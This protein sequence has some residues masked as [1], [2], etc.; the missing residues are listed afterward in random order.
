M[1]ARVSEVPDVNDLLAQTKGYPAARKLAC[2][3]VSS[4]NDIVWHALDFAMDDEL[5]RYDPGPEFLIGGLK[6]VICPLIRVGLFGSSPWPL[7]LSG[8]P[9]RT[10]LFTPRQQR[11]IMVAL[12]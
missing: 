2:D 12:P 10:C 9:C 8:R 4:A 6:W 11:L 1:R 5:P 3:R 7:R